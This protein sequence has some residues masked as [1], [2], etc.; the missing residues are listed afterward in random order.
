MEVV[1]NQGKPA[2]ER[3]SAQKSILKLNSAMNELHATAQASIVRN[4]REQFP[5]LIGL[6]TGQGGQMLL[7]PPGK[8]PLV[9]ARVPVIYELAKA[10]AH[11]PMGIYELV[12]PYLKTPTADSSWKG[13]MRTYRGQ[14]QTALDNLLALDVSREDRDAFR[15]ILEPISASGS[16]WNAA[17]TFPNWASCPSRF[18]RVLRSAATS[19]LPTG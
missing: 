9:A 19:R 18:L 11:S 2:S 14:N 15:G 6:F 8:P 10:V 3:D 17:L 12:V 5:I 1:T 16:A 4:L 13:P 7:Y